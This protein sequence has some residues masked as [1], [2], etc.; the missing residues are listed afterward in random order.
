MARNRAKTVASLRRLAERP[1]TRSEGEVAK[2]MLERFGIHEWHATPY[3]AAKYPA[4]TRIYYC[5]WCYRNEAGT[6][7]KQPAKKIQGQW[8]LRIKFDYL[9]SPRWVPITSRLGCHISTAKFNGREAEIMYHMS[10]DIEG[11]RAAIAKAKEGE[12]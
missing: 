10:E 2:R 11:L 3:D 5:Y 7:C 1:G 12:C 9:K 6:V 8:W 4:D